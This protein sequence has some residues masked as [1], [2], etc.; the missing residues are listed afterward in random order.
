MARPYVVG[1]TGGSGSG[2]TSFVR[3]LRERLGDGATFLW[4]DDYYR[5]LGEQA[6]DARGV[7]NFDLPTSIDSA[8]MATDLQT[9]LDG[10]TVQR[11]EY[12]FETVYRDDRN[13]TTPDRPSRTLTLRRAPV[14][15]VEGLFVMHEPALRGAM[16]L[17]VFIDA[18]DVAKLKRRIERDRVERG[19]PLEDVLYRYEAHVLPSY[20]RYI[21]PHRATVDLVVNN[22]TSYASGLEV[23]AAHLRARA[24][25]VDAGAEA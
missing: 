11:A 4:Q 3:E 14:I 23:L 10:G 24:A 22:G 19:L 17:A 18:S 20:E 9:L 8:A 7:H 5:P 1:V 13:G 25:A 16:D 6:T 21:K 2:K 12:M 15:V